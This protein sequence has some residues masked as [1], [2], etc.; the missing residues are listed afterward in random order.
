M[1]RS[2]PLM[3]QTGPDCQN[4]TG[5]GAIFDIQGVLRQKK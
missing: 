5:H 2:K 1:Y 4:N 3:F